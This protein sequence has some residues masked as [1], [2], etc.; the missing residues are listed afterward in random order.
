[1]GRVTELELQSRRQKQ[2][3]PST[4]TA[5]PFEFS[6]AM[7]PSGW[8]AYDMRRSVVYLTSTLAPTGTWPVRRDIVIGLLQRRIAALGGL[9][10]LYLRMERRKTVVEVVVVPGVQH[11]EMKGVHYHCHRH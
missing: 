9:S 6:P 10:S 8:T 1:M 5:T 4:I 3:C 11:Q 2:P 7:C